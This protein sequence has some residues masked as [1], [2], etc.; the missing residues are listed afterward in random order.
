MSL[1]LLVVLLPMLLGGCQLFQTPEVVTP[2]EVEAPA[3]PAPPE[4]VACPEPTIIE[5]TQDCPAP[6]SL[7][8]PEVSAPPA[9]ETPIANGR[10]GEKQLLIIGAAEWIKLDPPNLR[11]RARIDTG[12]EVSSLS[13]TNIIPFE[14]EGKRWVRFNF[15]ANDKTEE[16]VLE[17]PVVQ[18][19]K[20]K[21]HGTDTG[22]VIA[23]HLQLADIEEEIDV[24][25][26]N[27]T[28]AEFPL[29][30]GRNFLTD[31]AVVDVSKTYTIRD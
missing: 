4:P 21:Q 17:R 31:N 15:K 11:V 16:V 19:N 26:H 10:A 20:A 18:K 22:L 12:A 9:A 3:C 8:A 13:A 24:V 23:L 25:L 6:E 28:G 14:R 29:L 1:R 7:A 5:V 27:G 30:V 2:A